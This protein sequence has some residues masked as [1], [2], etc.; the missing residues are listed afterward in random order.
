MPDNL[1]FHEKT[2][3]RPATVKHFHP[4]GTLHQI[5]TFSNQRYYSNS[6]V[7]ELGS[8]VPICQ[9]KHTV[10]DYFPLGHGE[11]W[12]F[13]IIALLS[14]CLRE[15]GLTILLW[16]WRVPP[17]CSNRAGTLS[18]RSLQDASGLMEGAWNLVRSCIC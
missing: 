13:A 15:S 8:K 11:I 10:E 17:Y 2:V 9:I 12:L 18:A 6:V 7:A 3:F 1:H 14:H 16:Q 5:A 4:F